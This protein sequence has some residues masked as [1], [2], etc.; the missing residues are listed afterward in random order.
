[1]NCFCLLPRNSPI[2]C[3]LKPFL[4]SRK[5]ATPTGVSGTK[6]RSIRY[7]MPFSG[8]LEAQE[9]LEKE[10]EGEREKKGKSEDTV[11]ICDYPTA[12]LP[13]AKCVSDEGQDLKRQGGRWWDEMRL[14][15]RRR[16]LLFSLVL[17]TN[18]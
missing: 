2:I 18:D 10:R 1:M 17:I 3:L 12:L 8:F 5:W 15:M 11:Q 16:E 9:R 6:F 4:W 14:K 7:W 13:R